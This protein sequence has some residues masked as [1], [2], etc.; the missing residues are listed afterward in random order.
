MNV[1]IAFHTLV[2]KCIEKKYQL[3]WLKIMRQHTGY[4]LHL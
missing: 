4:A 1:K 2:R 3:V